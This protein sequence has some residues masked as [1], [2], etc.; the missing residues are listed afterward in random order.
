MSS[1]GD[2]VHRCLACNELA[3]ETD[4][5]YCEHTNK[6]NY[7]LYKCSKCGF[8]WEVVGCDEQGSL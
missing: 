1:M 8:S 7:I 3:Y 5:E 6:K 4:V 2:L